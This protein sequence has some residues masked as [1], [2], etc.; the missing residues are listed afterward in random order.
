MSSSPYDLWA[1]FKVALARP[2]V[3]LPAEVR[4][5]LADAAS[6]YTGE[7]ALDVLL[8]LRGPGK[9]TV[10]TLDRLHRRNLHLAIARTEYTHL[11]RPCLSD[12]EQNQIFIDRVKK[13]R[14]KWP[15]IKHHESPPETLDRLDREL[16]KAFRA[17]EPP[18][19]DRALIQ[20][21]ELPGI[22]LQ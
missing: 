4:D 21:S 6:R 10:G 12:R 22:H 13:F 18:E 14:R 3:P 19:N 7:V 15:R 5:W 16:F 17:C 9:R 8:D 1:R 20:V 2:E 11:G